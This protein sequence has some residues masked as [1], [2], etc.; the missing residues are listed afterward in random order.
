MCVLQSPVSL[1][2]L[3]LSVLPL[4]PL[5]AACLPAYPLAAPSRHPDAPP[6]SQATL[7]LLQQ[8]HAT[9]M[10]A[11]R[12]V[13]MIKFH[14]AQTIVRTGQP[15]G[16]AFLGLRSAVGGSSQASRVNGCCC[17]LKHSAREPTHHRN[18]AVEMSAQP[19]SRAITEPAPH[20]DTPENRASGPVRESRSSWSSY[21]TV[22][23]P[24][25]RPAA[26]GVVWA[27]H[28]RWQQ[29]QLHSGLV[30]CRRRLYMHIEP[31]ALPRA[32]SGSRWQA[33]HAGFES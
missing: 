28:R 18:S 29:Q 9:R 32:R 19:D 1:H 4:L 16:H 24:G 13:F 26:S 27:R 17:V 20:W 10:P 14:S 30:G 6:P 2:A 22:L 15:K 25:S 12:G 3:L 23:P 5:S 7:P 11:R 8:F 31:A 33:A 21:V